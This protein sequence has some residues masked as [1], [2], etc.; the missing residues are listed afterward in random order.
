[1]AATSAPSGAHDFDFQFGEWRVHHRVKRP[2]TKDWMEFDGTSSVRPV[3]GGS[4]NV[5][6]N[7][8]DKASGVTRGVALRAF[9]Q[10]TGLWAIWW[11]DGRA[12]HGPIDPPVKG[13]F[14]KGVGTFYSDGAI[15]GKAMRVRYTWSRITPR[16]ARWEQAYSFDGEKSWDTN[17]VMDF[18]RTS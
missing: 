12:P 3:M 7:R 18:E 11:V 16:S 15:D 13:R 14:D 5:E 10:E 9:D 4:A 1:M 8:F 17:W 6:D 2:A